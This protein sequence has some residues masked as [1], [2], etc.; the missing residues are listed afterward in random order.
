MRSALGRNEKQDRYQDENYSK[1]GSRFY[2]LI[3]FLFHF[4]VEKQTY[5]YY[6]FM[7]FFHDLV[8]FTVVFQNC[9]IPSFPVNNVLC[10]GTP[11]CDL[12]Y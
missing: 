2:T 8:Y 1:K 11:T 10:R 12:K 4:S 9:S 6:A 7:I 3:Y 5:E